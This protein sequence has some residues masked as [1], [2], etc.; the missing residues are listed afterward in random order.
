M[1]TSSLYISGS[2]AFPLSILLTY[3]LITA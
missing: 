1:K 3:I 2:A